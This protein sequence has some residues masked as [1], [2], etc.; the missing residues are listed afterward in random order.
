MARRS[1][2]AP[3]RH[4]RRLALESLEQRA[5]PATAP[6]DA[7]LD[8]GGDHPSQY[9][10]GAALKSDGEI[11][12]AMGPWPGGTALDF[13]QTGHP[14]GKQSLGLPQYADQPDHPAQKQLVSPNGSWIVLQYYDFDKTPGHV[15]KPLIVR[16][17]GTDPDSAVRIDATPISAATV[18]DVADNGDV[19]LL[20]GYR[21]SETTG[22]VQLMPLSLPSDGSGSPPQAQAVAIA[23]DGSVVV[24]TSGNSVYG[25]NGT[26]SAPT[27]WD[28]HG[29]HALPS[30]G[31]SGGA[32]DVSGDGTV[33]GG[34]LEDGYDRHAVVWAGGALVELKDVHGNLMTGSVSTVVNGL[35]G[36]PTKWAALGESNFG[37]WIAFSD[38]V[39]YP[40]S[41]WLR[42]HYGDVPL[43]SFPN[44]PLNTTGRQSLIGAFVYDNALE[45][46]TSDMTVVGW[47]TGM[48]GSPVYG[49][50][51]P[52]LIVAPLKPDGTPDDVPH[53]SDPRDI[54]NSDP[55]DV[56]GDGT[57]APADALII[58]DALNAGGSDSLA[59][60]PEL[61]A[62]YPS[63]DVNGDGHLS[64]A[65]ALQIIDLLSAAAGP[66]T[67]PVPIVFGPLP[68]P[69][70]IGGGAGEG[71]GL[72]SQ[73]DLWLSCLPMT[74]H[75]QNGNSR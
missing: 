8:V 23:A 46:I 3:P 24:G 29:P 69:T 44:A 59:D 52:H 57:V 38:G 11:R 53:D 64:P 30:L 74:E 34:Y 50:T 4:S 31:L 6:L 56:N 39:A 68:P 12:I 61:V 28:S 45:I 43:N 73:S 67:V 9:F 1:F 62:A 25:I 58:I 13:D 66:V 32:A 55:R 71:S 19:L 35:G 2:K 70:V 10:E 47:T 41:D 37:Q 54:N 15:I 14:V 5:V 21:W 20:G 72:L 33:I 60:R 48:P 27:I 75:R 22:I 42:Q 26:I 17:N 18:I 63:I 65:D 49:Q 40:L 51:T 16:W 36:D 7:L